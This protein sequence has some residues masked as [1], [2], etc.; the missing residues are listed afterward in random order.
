M[1]CLFVSPSDG[2]GLNDVVILYVDYSIYIFVFFF[3]FSFLMCPE[4]YSTGIWV[5]P[6]LV[7]KWLCF[8]ELS[9]IDIN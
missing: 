9:L 8:W 3:F 6:G 5:M 1:N 4:Q 7:Y 2:Q